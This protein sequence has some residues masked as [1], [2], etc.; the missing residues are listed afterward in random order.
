MARFGFR[1]QTLGDGPPISNNVR[2]AG[3]M[4]ISMAAFVCN[5]TLMKLLST[6]VPLFQAIFVRGL[7][8]TCLILMLGGF[9][10]VLHY[11]PRGRDRWLIGLRILGETGATFLFLTAL[12]NMPIANATAI[13]QVEP[14]AVTIGAALF[15]GEKVGWRRY[16]AVA[17]GFLGVMLII[18][19]GSDG[20]TSYSLI[21]LAAMCFMVLRDLVTRRLS[22]GVPSVFVT[23][24]TAVVI[25]SSAGLAC[26]F[27]PWQPMTG[28]HVAHLSLTAIFLLFGYLFSVLAIRTGEIGYTSPFRYSVLI[29]A[30]MLGF[31]VFGDIPDIWMLTGSAIVVSTGLYTFHR[32][33]VLTRSVRTRLMSNSG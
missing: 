20:F 18:R 29:W 9:Y 10:G 17:V 4:M 7:M 14:L 26:L 15:L 21:A 24:L 8:A 23:V 33:M 6:E 19:P 2:G 22:P 11:R 13:L 5:D 30:I 27:V 31:L 32:E 28:S 12:F 25:T 16:L 3:F 1:A